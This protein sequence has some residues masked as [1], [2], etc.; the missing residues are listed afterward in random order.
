VIPGGGGPLIVK[1]PFT[2]PAAIVHATGVARGR[3]GRDVITQPLS[4]VLKPEPV[5]IAVV[6]KPPVLGFRKTL[7][8]VT[9]PRVNG[10]KEAVS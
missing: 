6:P 7:P 1:T 4:L 10:E 5:T 9:V 8:V 2:F 3:T